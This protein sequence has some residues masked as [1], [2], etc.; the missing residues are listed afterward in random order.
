[1]EQNIKEQSIKVGLIGAGEWGKNLL[2]NFKDLNVLEKVC[3]L[4]EKTLEQRKKEYPDLLFTDRPEDILEENAINAVVIA[5]PAVTHYELVRS[6]LLNGKHVLVEKPMAMDVGHGEELVALAAQKKKTLMVGHILQYHPAVIKIKELISRGELGKIE[7]IYSNRLNIGK[8]R[9]EENILWSFAPHDVSVILALIN[10]YPETV[11]AQGGAYL[12][13]HL[14]DVTM[15]NFS[16]KSGIKGHIFVS[17][18]HPFKEQKLVIVGSK[19]MLVFDDMSKEKL[20]LYEHKI[21]WINQ[22]PIAQRN[23]PIVIPVDRAEPLKEEC[24]HFLDCVRTGKMP[25]T[26]SEEGLRVLRF[27]KMAEDSLREM[28]VPMRKER[29][30]IYYNHPTSVVEEG[31]SIG[32]DTKIWHFTHIMKGARIGDN[33]NI[34]QNV[35]IDKKAVIGNRVKIQN[36]VSVYDDVT[37]ED[38]VFCGPSMVFTNVINPRSFIERKDEYRKTIV[39]KGAS[40]GANATVVCGH[41]VGRYAFVGAG[42]VVTRDIPDYAL[43]VGVPARISGW[44]CKC[45]NKLSF[46]KKKARCLNCGSTYKLSGKKITAIKEK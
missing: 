45:G 8:L 5:A 3:D 28:G 15:T 7:Y 24:L 27:L 29:E 25:V 31:A 39:R 33:C 17:W 1:M 16:F 14:Y 19:K 22:V 41:T 34:G 21:E 2:R 46:K 42:S 35:Y 23:E 38:E 43:V 40:I 6:A 11:T 13:S 20:F 4:S 26:N 30:K 9:T 18:L 36:N 32:R 44:M 37:L 12:Q 10:E